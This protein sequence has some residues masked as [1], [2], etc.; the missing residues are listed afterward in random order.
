M[1]LALAALTEPPAVGFGDIARS[2]AGE[3]TPAVVIGCGPVALG[4]VA[5]L[6]ERGGGPRP[7]S[8]A[9]TRPSPPCAGRR[10]TSRY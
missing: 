9:W 7:V 1:D 3:G 8:A 4:A 5:A 6:L 10:S 2:C